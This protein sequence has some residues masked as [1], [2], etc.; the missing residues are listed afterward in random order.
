MVAQPH[1][2]VTVSIVVPKGKSVSKND[3]E[4]AR[5]YSAVRS[6]Q[7]YEVNL[8]WVGANNLAA[9]YLRTQNS[10]VV[11]NVVTVAGE[12]I[13]VTLRPNISDP[14]APAGGMLYN[15]KKNG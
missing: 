15:L 12:Q 5:L 8:K 2:S 7:A 13:T 11:K 14:S 10:E 3:A 4:V 6:D 1:P 9:E